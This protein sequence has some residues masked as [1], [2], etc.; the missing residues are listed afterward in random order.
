MRRMQHVQRARI[1][2]AFVLATAVA[3]AQT[4]PTI[5]TPPLVTSLDGDS[6]YLVDGTVLHGAIGEVT[7]GQPVT[8]K[9]ADGQVRSIAWNSIERV[10]IDRAKSPPTQPPQQ[11]RQ[12][13]PSFTPPTTWLHLDGDLAGA[14][15][16]LDMRAGSESPWAT[17]CAGT[18]DR[19]LPRTTLYRIGGSG[20]RTSKVFQLDGDRETL[21]VETASSTAFAG[22]LTL[23]I[24][25]GAAFL[26]GLGFLLVD[27]LDGAIDGFNDNGFTLAGAVLVGTGLV[28]LIVGLV[29]LHGNLRTTAKVADAG[30]R[31]GIAF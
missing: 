10:D 7:P 8:I 26:Q 22:G 15:Q 30:H 31:F 6:L 16:A 5:T 1:C 23:T 21:H 11:P 2:L 27:A 9:L 12:S 14:L 20:V 3:H 13:P 29:V 19:A 4:Q 17:V 28:T 24:V 18:C 25:G